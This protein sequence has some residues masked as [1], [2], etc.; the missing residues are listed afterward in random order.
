MR[1]SYRALL[2]ICPL[3]CALPAIAQEAGLGTDA[4]TV[5]AEVTLYADEE[6][7]SPSQSRITAT[8]LSTRFQGAGL[9]RILRDMAGVTVQGGTGEGGETAINIRGLQD[10]GRVAV[11]IDGM[12]QNFAR[13]GHGANGTFGVDTE[14]LRDIT[15]TRGP[16]A[17]VGAYG[18]AVTMRSVAAEDLLLDGAE[19]GGEVRLRYG[20]LL[21]EPT[22]HAAF[23][24]KV[25]TSADLT[26]AA[27]RTRTDDYTAPDGTEVY[28]AQDTDSR[29]ATF[30]LDLED[31]G[32][33][34]LGFTTLDET[35]VTGRGTGTPRNTK[36]STDSLFLAYANDDALNGWAIDGRIYDT[37]T[38]LAQQGLDPETL[39]PN[40]EDRSYDTA[41]TG[42][43]LEGRKEAEIAGRLH[44][45]TLRL[46]GFRD[47]VTTDDPG[48]DSLTPSG[49]REIWS[50]AL[51]DRVEIGAALVTFGLS[52]DSYRMDSDSGDA[53][54]EALSPR[55]AVELPLAAGF[56]L[57]GAAGLTFRP[58][59]LNET[60]VDGMHPE[61]ADFPI[62]PNPDL[63]PER[64]RTM[65]IGLG[66]EGEGVLAD[67][68]SLRVRATM[69]RNQVNDYIGLV[70]A[71]GIFDGYYQYDNI[72]RV[73]IDGIEL[74]A[75][76]ERDG[77]YLSLSGQH[78]D[79]TNQDTG[80]DLSR[81]MP[82]RIS[83]TAGYITPDERREFGTRV[84]HSAAKKDGDFA[85]DAWTTVD[86]Y[87]RQ[88][89]TETASLNLALN[90]I[91]DET[92]T[93]HLETQPSPGFNAQAS[94]TFRF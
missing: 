11:T 43:R 59:T 88:D 91:F 9:D 76:Y 94:L 1:L 37:G 60:L 84:V 29:L 67:A 72:S 13:S 55:I 24:T 74:E 16:G 80:E 89:L 61:P 17:E 81:V 18:G 36:L 73:K 50:L 33:A 85:T 47:R 56:S 57:H 12:R 38:T 10:Q 53:R 78:M 69:F 93:Q 48:A 68:D 39:Q 32:R 46:E 4:P 3:V 5:L 34:T 27:T 30:G 49:T 20:D 35:Y 86:L 14:M 64:A 45:F 7:T 19:H 42:L 40:G 63:D 71:G 6:D 92:Y 22:V 15:V 87:L 2:M 83:L 8:D 70:W 77:Y 25:G 65:E 79:G 52:A 23:A 54:G 90:N 41:T 28:A 58:P 26:I 31:G 21:A 82:D 51:T 66:Y 62:R 75:A 44:D